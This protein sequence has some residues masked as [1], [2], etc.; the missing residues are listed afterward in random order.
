MT[1]ITGVANGDD[2][3]F[4]KH[5]L[6]FFALAFAWSWTCWLLSSAVTA[7]RVA[8]LDLGVA[9]GAWRLPLFS[10]LTR[11]KAS[12]RFSLSL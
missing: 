8:S 1:P 11:L 3:G 4:H 7:Q 2:T 9:W 10:W 6:A 12:H 5:L